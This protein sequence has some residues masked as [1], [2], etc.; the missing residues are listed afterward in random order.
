MESTDPAQ[1]LAAVDRLKA[2]AESESLKGRPAAIPVLVVATLLFFSSYEIDSIWVNAGAP[3]LWT[4]FIAGWVWWLRSPNR[5]KPRLKLSPW[6]AREYVPGWIAVTLLGVLIATIGERISW[7]LGG[8]LMAALVAWGGI[9]VQK[10]AR[11]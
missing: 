11:R 5:A 3:I 6:P 9:M 8:I 2:R 7:I 4:F 10:L 1:Q